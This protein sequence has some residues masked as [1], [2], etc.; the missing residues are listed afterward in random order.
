MKKSIRNSDKIEPEKTAPVT[1][2]KLKIA[3]KKTLRDSINVI[4]TYQNQETKTFQCNPNETLK[5]NLTKFSTDL[6]LKF[7]S[8][9]FL[10]SGNTVDEDIYNKPLYEIMNNQDKKEGMMNVLAYDN[11]FSDNEDENTNMINIIIIFENEPKRIKVER[12]K[13]FIDIFKSFASEK[14]LDLNLLIFKYGDKRIINLNQKF[15]DIA[16]Q[17]DKKSAGITI[18]VYNAIPATIDFTYNSY[19]KDSIDCYL[20]DKMK[21]IFKKYCSK[22]RLDINNLIFNHKFVPVNMEY[23][24]QDLI[25]E[26]EGESEDIALNIN[27]SNKNKK[28]IKID[29]YDKKDT[30]KSDDYRYSRSFDNITIDKKKLKNILI[31]L[32][33]I[34]GIAVIIIVATKKKEDKDEEDKK[35]SDN[36]NDINDKSTSNSNIIGS[37]DS[38]KDS[39]TIK[40]LDTIKLTVAPTEKIKDLD[41]I[42]ITETPT[43]KITVTCESGFFIPDNED[44]TLDNCIQCPLEGCAKCQ[45]TSD[46]NECISC[47]Y[48]RAVYDNGIIKECINDCEEGAEEKCSKC[49]KHKSECISCNL[50]YSLDGGICKIDYFIEAVY[51]T[52]ENG[53]NID[54]FYSFSSYSTFISYMIIDGEKI[55]NI[56]SKHQ[57]EEGGIHKVLIKPQINRSFSYLFRGISNLI[58]VSFTDFNEFKPYLSLEELFYNC[59]KLTSVDF[60]KI[61]YSYSGSMSKAFRECKNLIYINFGLQ[62]FVQINTLNFMFYKCTSLTSIDFST[63]EVSK[64]VNFESVFEGCTSLQIINLNGFKLNKATYLYRMFYNCTS[65]KSL[66]LSSFKPADLTDM[67]FAFYNCHSLTSINLNNFYTS[68]VIYMQYLFYNCSQLK[69][70]DIS[71]FNT[72]NV[73]YMNS[74]FANCISLT[75]IIFSSSFLTNNILNINAIFNNCHSLEEIN[76][77]IIIPNQ[78]QYAN[79]LFSNCYSLKAINISFS[80]LHNNVNLKGIFSGCSSLTSIDLSSGTSPSRGNIFDEIFYDCPNLKYIK[81]FQFY[82]YCVNRILFNQNISSSGTLLMPNKFENC[83]SSNINLSS[84]WNIEYY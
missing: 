10:Y 74:M 63:L 24:F 6:N 46:Q 53:D 38:I 8:L 23:T 28:I 18:L 41:T 69:I 60:S 73:K 50:G 75:S 81:F 36:N 9:Y 77:N 4:I 71:S 82:N 11:H 79:N 54:L 59:D 1:L 19:S 26:E 7:G 45:G 39:E 55:T 57:F 56:K 30:K 40:D 42:K 52:L 33:I 80:N 31:I 25:D 14:G 49:L 13:P 62:K 17:Y 61:Y 66:D 15:D 51:Q 76:T 58:S 44:L 83:T 48:L 5:D 34:L 16:S 72:Q 29:V 27:N 47:G 2:D 67:S 84:G 70:V 32:G 21:G 37:S 78:C 12:D 20:Q 65:L 3:P 68:R 22:N 35:N 43:E 64:A